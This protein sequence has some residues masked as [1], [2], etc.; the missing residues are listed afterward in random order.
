VRGRHRGSKA[1]VLTPPDGG[2]DLELDAQATDGRH[3]ARVDAT[4]GRAARCAA[5]DCGARLE[6]RGVQPH[7]LERYLRSTD[8]AFEHKAAEI[9]GLYRDPPQ[10]AAV[11]CVDEKTAQSTLRRHPV[12]PYAAS[13]IDRPEYRTLRDC[14][15]RGPRPRWTAQIPPLIDTSNPA[16]CGGGRDRGVLLRGF[17]RTQVGVDLGAPAAWAALQDVRVM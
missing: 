14:G 5:H 11:F 10:H 7:R 4:S 3:A 6:A 16:I 12:T 17:L 1:R 13:L 15:R 9:L 8:P 2:S